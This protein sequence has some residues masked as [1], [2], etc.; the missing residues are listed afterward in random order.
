MSAYL[1]VVHV[2]G[3]VIVGFGAIMILPLAVALIVRDGAELLYGE[4]VVLVLLAGA[5]LWI[6]TRPFRRDLERRHGFLLVALAWVLLPALATLPLLL[7]IPGLSFTDAY[8]E[9]V[10]AMTTTAVRSSWGWT[11]CLR[12]STSGAGCCNGWEEWG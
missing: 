7:A 6:A 11:S 5:L 10:S 2:L 9:T 1:P 4:S 12:R 3:P 8:F